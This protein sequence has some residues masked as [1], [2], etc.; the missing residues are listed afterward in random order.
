MSCDG[1]TALC[2]IVHHAVKTN[3]ES[4][5]NS[6]RPCRQSCGFCRRLVAGTRARR[7]Q[8][9]CHQAW[10]IFFHNQPLPTLPPLSHT[11]PV[12]QVN[13]QTHGIASRETSCVANSA[14]TLATCCSTSS[15]TSCDTFSFLSVPFAR[16]RRWS[17]LSA[18]PPGHADLLPHMWLV[19]KDSDTSS[20]T[21][22]AT[23]GQCESTIKRTQIW[24]RNSF[25]EINC[26]LYDFL[27]LVAFTFLLLFFFFSFCCEWRY[28]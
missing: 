19:W 28:S 4:K 16:G 12:H 7:R 13:Y 20:A 26:Y 22:S 21:S 24:R 17:S 5:I 6:S 11:I 23:C 27:L 18:S 8:L 9:A 25:K 1:K 14:F 10:P 2:A 15:A 3:S